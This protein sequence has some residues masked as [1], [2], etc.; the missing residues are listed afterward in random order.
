MSGTLRSR[1]L[2]LDDEPLIALDIARELQQNDI[3]VVG[4]AFSVEEAMR[5]LDAVGC[6]AAILDIKLGNDDSGRVA[7]RLLETGVPLLVLTGYAESDGE[8]EHLP[9]LGKPVNYSLLLTELRKLLL[10]S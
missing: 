5:L 1:V 4:P 10:R 6:E 8:F 2:I 3:A 7:R 9:R